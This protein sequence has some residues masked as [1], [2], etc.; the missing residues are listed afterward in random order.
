MYVYSIYDALH[1]INAQ[2][3][4][5]VQR[6]MQLMDVQ[7]PFLPASA[8]AQAEAEAELKSLNHFEPARR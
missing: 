4:K 8:E 3:V 5:I 1:A 2:L 6:I 7:M